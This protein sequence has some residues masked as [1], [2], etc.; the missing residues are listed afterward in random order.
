MP[1]KRLKKRNRKKKLLSYFVRVKIRQN[2]P[3]RNEEEIRG[4]QE[5]KRVRGAYKREL[6]KI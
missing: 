5:T 3:D 1:H 4:E 2:E 6:C